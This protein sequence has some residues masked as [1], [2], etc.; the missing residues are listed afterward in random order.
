[1]VLAIALK[2][3][4]LDNSGAIDAK[5]LEGVLK[6]FGQKATQE[7]V[8]FLVQTFDADSSGVIEW[9]EFLQVRFDRLRNF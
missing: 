5:E 9:G 1:M 6:H 7:D 4:F 8:S 2:L 3:I